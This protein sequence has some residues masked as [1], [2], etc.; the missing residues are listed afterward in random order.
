VFRL[1]RYFAVASLIAIAAAAAALSW[2]YERQAVG[3]L[4]EAQERHHVALTRAYAATLWPHFSALLREADGLDDEGLR[5][6]PEV[7]SV[8]RA[9]A[10]ELAGSQV[11]EVKIYDRRGRTVFSTDPA[12][13]GEDKSG[14]AGLRSALA[15]TPASELTHR[16][17]SSAFEQ[18]V[19][20]VDVVSSYVPVFA[21]GAREPE[22]VFEIYSDITPLLAQVREA[23]GALLLRV[24]A[25]LLALY[26]VLLLVIR[27]ADRA[28]RRQDAERR[29]VEESL[30]AARAE[31]ARSEEFHR[32]L[33]EQSSD[34][35]LVLGP[36]LA[37]R[38]ATP[39]WERV[40]GEPASEL[41][42]KTLVDWAPEPERAAIKRWL[43]EAILHP[44]A[45][46]SVEFRRGGDAGEPRFFEAVAT[47]K[48]DH[49]AI[50]GIVVNVRDITSRKRAEMEARRLALYDGL[51]GL[52]NRE[53]FH[54]QLRA[55]IGRSK[56]HDEV[57]A[58]LFLDLDGFKRVNDT[59]GHHA[60]DALLKEV[61]ARMR[62]ALREGDVLGRDLGEELLDHVARMGGD[63]F[64]ILLPRLRRPEDAAVV[65]RR[66]I[67]RLSAPYALG[68]QEV[69]ITASIG[70]AVCP[71]D[72]TTVD[73]LLNRADAAMYHAKKRGKNNFQ[74]FSETLNSTVTRSLT[75]ETALRRALE[76]GEFVLHYQPLVEAGSGRVAACEAL[77]R[78]R[79]PDLGLLPP[80]RF[81]RL[82]EDS[83]LI[84]PIGEWVL[85]AAC[86]QAAVWR[87][88]GLGELCVSVNLA[89]LSFKQPGLVALVRECLER[90]AL[91][92]GRLGIELT[93]SI[94]MANVDVALDTL[95]ELK[96]LRIKLA[97][98]DFGT[99][100]SSLGYLSGLP[101]DTLKI[102]R[103]F[104]SR[105]ELSPDD[106]RIVS[107]IIALARSLRLEVVA[108]GVETEA[109]RAFLAENGCHFLQGYLFGRPVPA[110]EFAAL[111]AAGRVRGAA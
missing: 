111:A 99:G 15:G 102:D 79:H 5:R 31:I 69:I 97:I 82:A 50:A 55:V 74:F 23:R 17:R 48:L 22:G 41:V 34:A 7:G 105:L 77:I 90:H 96:A 88:A 47:N 2:L 106:Q 86:A 57:A 11:L 32:S 3:A 52:A 91:P 59:L 60:G 46:R 67:E 27:H 68:H 104:V 19:S 54:E 56:R 44:G 51:T 37:V 78:W 14:N 12:Q 76:R 38:Q 62:S 28:I 33:I 40:I 1:L 43:A 25:V 95:R 103:S 92:P 39:S 75:M 81:I 58:V 16:E 66:L 45:P 49:P 9:I 64:T 85:G 26:L 61:A 93:E 98:D 108:E 65:A 107:A 4:I 73:A 63:E 8:H 110:A 24:S 84:V 101:F 20:E 100:Y 53:L 80:G 87:E 6:R 42:G 18:T 29:E 72:A 89:S 71:Q 10:G 13:I 70:I 35:V 94:V 36:E 83:G 21:R 109:Q 30:R